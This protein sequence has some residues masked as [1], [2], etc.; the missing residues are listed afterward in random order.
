M[1]AFVQAMKDAEDAKVRIAE[2]E[3][4][5]KENGRRFGGNPPRVPD[6]EKVKP[7]PKAQRNFTDPESRIQKTAD[8]FIQG[9]TAVLAVYAIVSFWVALAFTRQRFRR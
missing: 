3:Q 6:P 9:Y 4:Q 2:R 5:E 7:A 8:G 1:P